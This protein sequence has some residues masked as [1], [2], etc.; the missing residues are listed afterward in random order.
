MIPAGQSRNT[1]LFILLTAFLNLAGIGI[2]APVLPFITGKYVDRADVIVV[3]SLL[4]TAY[5]FFQFIAT[6]TLG[7]LSD[8]Y[9]RRP[10]LL[11]SLLG[12]AAGY[13]MLG[14]GGSIAMLFT[15][16]IIDGITGGNLATIYAYA[17][18]ITEPKERTRFFGMLGSVAG[19][20]FVFGPLVGLIA[21][22]LTGTYEAPLYFAALLT[23][24]NVVWGY[25]VMPESLSAER[26]DKHIT[27]QRLNPLTQLV[28]VFRIPQIRLLL[29]GTLLWSMAFAALQSNLSFLAE[30]RLNWQADQT[31][32]IFFIVGLVGI[33]TQ[34]LVVRRLLPILG[35]ARMTIL[36]LLFMMVG[37]LILSLV[38]ATLSPVFLFIGIIPVA[39]GNGL[40]IPSLS[41]LLSGLVSANEQG[42]IQGGNQ[43]IQALGRVI[44]PLW[45]GWIY[46]T[47]TASAP[48]LLGAGFLLAGAGMIF[49][50]W[51]ETNHPVATSAD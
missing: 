15:G 28:N 27:L 45:G 31:N 19:L 2:I 17:A 41:G 16:R 1:V 4:F 30:D 40:I 18:D 48:Y 29:I 51:R 38:A 3:G 35:E 9:G 46:T 6:P 22:R 32:L 14:I 42:R 11:I 12:S 5:S 25:F 50:A 7:A 44:G 8:R 34:G 10:V 23:L 26:R 33:I 13:L 37:F 39:F 47:I 24:V 43:S 21:Y 20:G 49:L 36:G